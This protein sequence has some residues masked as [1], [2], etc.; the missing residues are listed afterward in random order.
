M[1]YSLYRLYEQGNYQSLLDLN[2]ATTELGN[3][4][5]N[6]KQLTNQT[7]KGQMS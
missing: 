5:R 3:Q 4:S 6:S 2:R 7:K 1:F